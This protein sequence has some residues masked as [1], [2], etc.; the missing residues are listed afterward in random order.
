MAPLSNQPLTVVLRAGGFAVAAQLAR[1]T[2]RRNL[3]NW[4]EIVYTQNLT[5]TKLIADRY[6]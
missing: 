4:V 6:H 3:H 5:P 1:A 2:L